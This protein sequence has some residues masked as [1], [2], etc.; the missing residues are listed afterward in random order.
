METT[1]T[2]GVHFGTAPNPPTGVYVANDWTGIPTYTFTNGTKILLVF[3]HDNRAV[4]RFSFDGT[5]FGDD[6]ILWDAPQ[7]EPIY[8]SAQS[9]QVQN[10][11]NGS[12][13]VFQ[14]MGQW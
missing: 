10:Y 4:Y 2:Y 9:F 6:L 14:V 3:T 12:F 7:A 5:A 1:Y 8:M 11:V 13:A